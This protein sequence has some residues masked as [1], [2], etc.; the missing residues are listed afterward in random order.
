MRPPT[1]ALWFIAGIVFCVG[2]TLFLKELGRQGDVGPMQPGP[3]LIA[4]GGS[5]VIVSPRYTAVIRGHVD[6]EPVRPRPGLFRW[7][8]RLLCDDYGIKFDTYPSGP[9]PEPSSGKPFE[10]AGQTF[11]RNEREDETQFI[12]R[13]DTYTVILETSKAPGAHP[14]DEWL[15]SHILAIEPR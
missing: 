14:P 2:A 1:A 8:D 9:S 13:G 7:H 10:L 4:A 15:R 12:I 11:T 3:R 5:T 6:S